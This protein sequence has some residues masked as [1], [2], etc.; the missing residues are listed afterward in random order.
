[1]GRT[2]R[3]VTATLLALVIA[4]TLPV[5][6]FT[7]FVLV[8]HALDQQ[9]RYAREA[10]QI[11]GFVSTI[12]DRE[13]SNFAAL[14]KGASTS[15]ALNSGDFATFHAE[16]VR[17]VAGS[18]QIVVL[19]DLGD[20]LL[21]NTALPF[22]SAL[23]AAVPMSARERAVL[24]SGETLIGDAYRTRNDG[25][26]RIPV[27]R[28]LTI[29]GEKL[30]LAV[31]IPAHYFYDVI[32]P[33]APKD[34]V[35][36]LA[37]ANATI[38]ARSEENEVYAGEAALPSY[39]ALATEQSGS[40]RTNGFGGR[41]LLSGYTHSRLS[42]WITGAN[43]PVDI[44]EAPLWQSLAGIVAVALAA[45][46]L[47]ALISA[48][49]I[50]RFRRAAKTL[51]AEARS[52]DPA[53]EKPPATG[54]QEFDQIIDAL[55]AAR[56]ESEAAER[57]LLT[58]TQELEIVLE[59]VP[60][61]V[62]F[63]YDPKVRVVRRNAYAGRLLHLPDDSRAS[64]GSGAFKHLEVLKDG[65][66][67][68]A[69]N[70]PLQRAF[71]GETVQDEEYLYRFLEGG[72]VTLLTNAEPLRDA[73]GSIMGAVS[74]S[75]DITERRRN[76]EHQKLL[77][78]ELNHRVKNTLTTVQSIARRSLRTAG[79][80]QEAERSLADRLVAIARAYDVLTRENW[81]G[82]GVASMLE[83][84]TA[85]YGQAGRIVIEGPTAWLSPSNSVT[86]S[87]IVHELAV[88]ATKYGA[89]SNDT[90]TVH[91]GWTLEDAGDGRMLTFTWR[92]SGGP[93]VAKPSRNGFGSDLLKRLTDSG[94]A[95]HR[96]DFAVEGLVC[97]FSLKQPLERPRIA[98]VDAAA[99]PS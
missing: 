90:G 50:R 16:A 66:A 31:T 47:A 23:P 82:S 25:E 3:T 30:A 36:T 22:G 14:I 56:T 21:L 77:I 44:V 19:R 52:T 89:L 27:A 45:A 60:A 73:D 79:S 26:W 53:R 62:W 69:E 32:K 42:G 2:G 35:V 18:E 92:E 93:P 5:M 74:V 84:T 70:L 46:A 48:A 28:P 76:D 24:E 12:V 13:L 63:T 78:N 43:I 34:W 95:E 33:A 88:N 72:E 9:D 86:L 1:M 59:A 57:A 58:R 65:A 38:V 40:F 98:P 4:L 10:E 87:L 51:L 55:A 15:S 7:A 41:A 96:M 80:L 68:P 37:D 29:N 91:I 17:L 61:A 83:S 64:I 39:L 94:G 8:R 97:V 99:L 81:Q 85:G 6:A 20:R 11:A 54:L 49:F 71:R 67:C 75:V